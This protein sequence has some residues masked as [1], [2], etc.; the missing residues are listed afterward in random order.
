MVFEDIIKS[1]LPA[2]VT[3]NLPSI[4]API[5][6]DEL[7]NEW[8][9]LQIAKKELDKSF[10]VHSKVTYNILG[11]II[12][13]LSTQKSLEETTALSKQDTNIK[14]ERTKANFLEN[15]IKNKDNIDSKIETIKSSLEQYAKSKLY[16]ENFMLELV[17]NPDHD[18][19]CG[20]LYFSEIRPDLRLPIY[21]LF[22]ETV[23]SFN[24]EDENLSETVLKHFPED[25]K[26]FLEEL[27]ISD[28]LNK[29][30]NFENYYR[31]YSIKYFNRTVNSDF[32]IPLFLIEEN[33]NFHDENMANRSYNTNMTQFRIA[34]SKEN[35]GIVYSDLNHCNKGS[36]GYNIIVD[37]AKDIYPTLLDHFTSWSGMRNSN[38]GRMYIEEFILA[39]GKII[40]QFYKH[41]LDNKIKVREQIAHIS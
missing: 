1:M 14:L 7:Y 8:Y 10:E 37:N 18:L 29:D 2:K 13:E 22:N 11:T 28:S 38:N 20:R 12:D 3:T 17:I 23:P 36:E 35:N 21:Y 32:S 27:R 4:I 16:S 40:T 5:N 9:K 25:A 6:I 31:D 33:G 24:L 34:L 30:R 41:N 26:K 15:I 39:A 19:R